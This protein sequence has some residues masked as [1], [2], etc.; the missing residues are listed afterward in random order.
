MRMWTAKEVE[1]GAEGRLPF[2]L[3]C[4]E[5]AQTA[6]GDLLIEGLIEGFMIGLLL[7]QN[8]FVH[9]TMNYFVNYL[10]SFQACEP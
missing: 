2:A 1:V 7:P 8:C 9:Y 3:T 4:Q 5:C 10:V 6:T